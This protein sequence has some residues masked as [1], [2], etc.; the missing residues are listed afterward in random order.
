MIT[1]YA[2]LFAAA[3]LAATV[4]PF[5]SEIY[6]LKLLA[7]GHEPVALWLT[8]TTANTLGSMVNWA[9]GFYLLKFK[10][11]R[12]FYFND[13]QIARGQHWFNRYGAWSLLFAWLPVGGDA[14]TLIAGI[15]RVPLLLFVVLVAIGKSVRYL[16]VMGLQLPLA[17]IGV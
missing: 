5:Y 17:G 3:F 10:D 14:L 7:D 1:S 2:L 15:M 9:L 16:V 11:K 8:A 4:L 12:W 13:R 6:F